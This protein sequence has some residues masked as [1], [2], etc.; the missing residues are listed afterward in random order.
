MKKLFLAGMLT[1]G[2]TLGFAKTTVTLTKSHEDCKTISINDRNF[3]VTSIIN[4]NDACIVT[5]TETHHD[6]NGNTVTQSSTQTSS[7]CAAARQACYLDLV[8]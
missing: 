1:F 5:V 3:V 7:S 6:S 8:N 2:G 4:E